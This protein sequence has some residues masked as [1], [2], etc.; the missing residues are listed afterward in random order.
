MCVY[1]N[2]LFACNIYINTQADTHKHTQ[3]HLPCAPSTAAAC[4]NSAQR[5]SQRSA[6]TRDKNPHMYASTYVCI[7]IIR[8]YDIIHME[9]Y[10]YKHTI[11]MHI[12]YI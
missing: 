10:T 1:I 5:C 9:K 2:I 8:M 6:N 12:V 3:T 4:R 7:C 11:H